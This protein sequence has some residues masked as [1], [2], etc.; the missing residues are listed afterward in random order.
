MNSLKEIK[1]F[2]QDTKY[3]CLGTS[4]TEGNVWTA[5]MTY[6]ADDNLN[7][8]FH[9]A[10]DS[11]HIENIKEN[12]AVSF[13]IY[14]SNQMLSEID[15]LQGKGIIGQIDNR[16]IDEVYRKFFIKHIPNDEIRAQF[17]PPIASFSGDDFPQKRF[18]KMKINELYKKNIEIYNVAR[19]QKVE[20]QELM[21]E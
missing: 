12:P 4:D 3:F 6:V 10:L 8:Y 11:V 20:L 15:G 18:F 9:S 5:P 13:S 14:D 1:S 17:A 21:K 19:R 2:I 16:E 7:I